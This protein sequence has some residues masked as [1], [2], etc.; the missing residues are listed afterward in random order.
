MNRGSRLCGKAAGHAAKRRSACWPKQLWCGDVASCSVPC[1]HGASR[2][3]TR[4]KTSSPTLYIVSYIVLDPKL[5]VV[6][7]F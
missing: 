7:P 2:T 6:H 1:L 4:S 3:T 5:L